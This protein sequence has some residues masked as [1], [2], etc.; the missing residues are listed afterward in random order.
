[1]D[2]H[3]F[4]LLQED[5]QQGA[6]LTDSLSSLASFDPP[7]PSQRDHASCRLCPVACRLLRMSEV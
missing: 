2:V 1:M 5:Q 6:E 3:S 4:Q 7:L